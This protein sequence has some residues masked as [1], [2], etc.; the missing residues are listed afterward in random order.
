M[1]LAA[2]TTRL[3][4]FEPKAFGRYTL[5]L[6]IAS[7]GMGEV[8]LARL[9]GGRGLEKLCVI[10]R[11]LPS[12]AKR[13]EFV[14]RFVNEARTLVQLS[15]GSI[16]QVWDMGVLQGTPFLVLE[17][18]DGKDL[19]RILTRVR[20]TRSELPLSFV[21]YVACKVLDALS[22][23]HRKRGGDDREMG[24][25]HRDIS[26]Q[27]ILVSY[28]GEVKIIDFGLVKSALNVADT[29]PSM[30]LGKF[31]YMSPEQAQ[32]QAVDFRSD[33]YSLGM[34]LYELISGKNPFVDVSSGALLE[35]VAHPSIAPLHEVKPSCPEEV[36]SA[37]MKA[38][39]P[40][41]SNRLLLIHAP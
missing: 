24:L 6:P 14:E 12:H 41:V 7:G 27:N 13:P 9:E 32:N 11:I 31:W 15:H 37:I 4:P 40:D 8:L 16:A 1:T 25:V 30:V 35:A 33:I 38:L 19:R 29:H 22:Y 36:S 10:K 18:I 17:Y 23:A 2:S 28:D 34:C 3:R 21:L 20:D 5:L 26:P 39:E